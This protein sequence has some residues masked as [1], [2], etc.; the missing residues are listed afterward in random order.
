MPTYKK[1]FISA[2]IFRVD[3]SPILHL[4]EKISPDYQE[5]IRDR[6]P[7]FE[8]RDV[9]EHTVHMADIEK[10][11]EKVF[12]KEW[13]FYNMDKSIKVT[14]HY[15]WLAVEFFRYSTFPNFRETVAWVYEKFESF[16]KPLVCTRIGLRYINSITL[17]EGHPLEWSNFLAEPIACG[18]EKFPE[19]EDLAR[20]M[21]QF[22]LK[23]DDHAVLVNF[24]MPNREFPAKISRKE[25]I[26][27]LDCS[28]SDCE[29]REPLSSL[30]A[31]QI[32]L[33]KIFELSITDQLRNIMEVIDEG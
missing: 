1:N 15:N 33:E 28:T 18:I 8:Q 27:D 2:V 17:P 26:L 25:F 10:K 4:Q 30:N 19:R 22:L 32:E 3:F 6:F 12:Y 20:A 9:V 11:E 14:A 16:Y 24:G 5:S 7:K 29:N 23:R 31:F 21:S 13:S